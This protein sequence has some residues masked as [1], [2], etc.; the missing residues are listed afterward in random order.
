MASQGVAAA[1]SRL[2]QM[3]MRFQQKQQQEREQRRL[4]MTDE[5]AGTTDEVVGAK[6]IT[7][8]KVRQMFDERRRGAGIDRANPLKPIASTAKAPSPIARQA[9]G[10]IQN[11]HQ[12]KNGNTPTVRMRVVSNANNVS[13]HARSPPKRLQNG[14]TDALSKEMSSLS[15]GLHSPEDRNNN[16]NNVVGR[17]KSSNSLKLNPV[18]TKKSPTPAP[19]AVAHTAKRPAN[20]SATGARQTPVPATSSTV[21]SS[22]PTAASNTKTPPRTSGNMASAAS[23]RMQPAADIDLTNMGLCQYCNRHFNTERLAKHEKVCEK[24]VHTKR[25][26][27]DAA[28]HRLR[29]TDAEKYQKKGQSRNSANNKSAY[30][31]AAAV[32]GKPA[33]MKK[34]NW[35][36]KHEEFIQAIRAAKQVQAHLARGGKLSDLPPPPPSENPDYI[37][38]PHCSRRFNESAAER[39]IPRCANMIHNKP[40]PGQAP[41]RRR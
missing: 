34:N 22:K 12:T 5:G 19:A 30:S 31:S 18:V 33:S 8:G 4:E 17:A 27:F 39:H 28:R 6:R 2:A 32:S 41:P 16:R 36:R 10:A 11:L 25:K 13:T 9:G 1:N 7:N 14:N 20:A 38:C 3:Q 26:I 35:R 40:K 24:M 23:M 29:G 21:R 37:Q 15:L